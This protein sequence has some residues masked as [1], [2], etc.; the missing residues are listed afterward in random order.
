MLTNVRQKKAEPL[1]RQHC[2]IG[3]DTV[4]DQHKGRDIDRG[5]LV[6]TWYRAARKVGERLQ[7][8]FAVL[9]GMRDLT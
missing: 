4:V 6:R 3:L 9:G 1:G 7:A 2:H 5:S 8:R